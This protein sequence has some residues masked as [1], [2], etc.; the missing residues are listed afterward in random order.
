MFFRETDIDLREMKRA[1]Q[2]FVGSARETDQQTKRADRAHDSATGDGGNFFSESDGVALRI[3]VDGPEGDDEVLLAHSPEEGAAHAVD[4]GARTSGELGL[5]VAMVS[6]GK[7]L[8][9]GVAL[10]LIK[11]TAGGPEVHVV[12][13]WR[14][15]PAGA[16]EAIGGTK[17][18]AED[19][20][21]RQRVEGGAESNRLASITRLA[22]NGDGILAARDLAGKRRDADDVALDGDTGALDIA[23]DA[24]GLGIAAEDRGATGEESRG[25]GD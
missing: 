10:E 4:L 5:E 22:N 14:I 17:V 11:G 25:D 3:S 1:G 9:L 2:R 6:H 20:D 18:P 19:T 8:E 24:D 15:F 12:R 23:V 7:S 21:D 16:G 13:R